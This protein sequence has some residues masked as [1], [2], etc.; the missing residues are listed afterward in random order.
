MGSSEVV[1]ITPY[2]FIG[3]F[4]PNLGSYRVFNPTSRITLLVLSITMVIGTTRGSYRPSETYARLRA[5]EVRR[6]CVPVSEAPARDGSA[7]QGS[8]T[9]RKSHYRTQKRSDD[10]PIQN[11]ASLTAEG[12]SA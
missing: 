12:V 3:I 6:E 11:D 8:E 5:N 9:M 1:L 10:A 7:K 4:Y 2:P